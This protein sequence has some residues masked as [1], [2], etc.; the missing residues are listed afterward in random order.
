MTT[1]SPRP[2]SSTALA[3]TRGAGGRRGTPQTPGF[4][5]TA[6]IPRTR[7]GATLPRVDRPPPS[8]RSALA[9]RVH[10]EEHQERATD[11]LDDAA[12]TSR[13]ARARTARPQRQHHQAER[14]RSRR[15]WPGALVPAPPRDA[16]EN[17]RQL[18]G[19]RRRPQGDAE[20]R[21]AASGIRDDPRRLSQPK[22]ADLD[23]VVV[24]R[25]ARAGRPR[26]RR[27]ARSRRP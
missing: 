26:T 19:S 1:A 23:G 13:P 9:D 15:P 16:S 12:G 5:R 11:H 6:T 21:S 2:P 20:A 17:S 24:G 22:F 14:E 4:S 7:W 8:G 10:G 27:A 18:H 3:T 25:L